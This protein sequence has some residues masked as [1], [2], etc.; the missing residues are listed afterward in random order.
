MNHDGVVNAADFAI[1]AA[2]YGLSPATFSQG[3]LN[4]DGKVDAG[5]FDILASRFNE[6]LGES[7]ASPS[8]P[9]ED[10]FGSHPVTG[11]IANSGNDESILSA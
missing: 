5:D 10:L 7:F 8:L 2:N 1:V 9:A 6:V 4:Y 3:D 11:M